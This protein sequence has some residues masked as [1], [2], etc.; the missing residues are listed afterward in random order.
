MSLRDLPTR[1]GLWPE[2]TLLD[3]VKVPIRGS[4]LAPKMR[5]HLMRGGYERAER[6]IL[7]RLIEPGDRVIELGASLGIVSTLLAKKVGKTG[8]V[9]S[10][11]PN[12][13]LKPH[14]E[15]QLSINAEKVDLLGLLGCPLWNGP[16]PE[17]IAK[18]RFSA[19]ADSLSGRAAGESGDSVPWVTLK[20]LAER[21]GMPEPTALVIDV[22]GGEQVWC[23]HAPNF[24]QSLRKIIV[25][26]HPHLIGEVKAGTCIQ[27]LVRE[28][29]GIAAFSGTVFG[30]TR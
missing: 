19:V 9:L 7:A 12:S 28:G 2:Y 17:E 1:I 21:G 15:R 3:G 6:K 18:Q 4:F 27:A 30:L 5:R 10:A 22:E 14:F 13:L 8:A 16:V 25:E 29:F 11:E 24:P 20:E 23:D 26:V